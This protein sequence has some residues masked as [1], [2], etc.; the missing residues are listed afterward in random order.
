MPDAVALP[1][2]ALL[3]FD[4]GLARIG[5]AVPAASQP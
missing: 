4:F 2:G 3:G 5:V 1:R